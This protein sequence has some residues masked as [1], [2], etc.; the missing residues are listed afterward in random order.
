VRILE[1]NTP[2][3]REQI[4]VHYNAAD[5]R[6]VSY[7]LCRISKGD[8]ATDSVVYI[9]DDKAR[10]LKTLSYIHYFGGTYVTGENLYL[11]TVPDTTFLA[12]YTLFSYDQNGN[13]AQLDGYNINRYGN[14]VHCSTKGFSNY[15]QT[16]NPQYSEDEI[17]LMDNSFDGVIN[18]SKNNFI[19]TGIY[20]KK[21]EYRADGRPRTCL[22][23][24]NGSFA[25]TLTFVYK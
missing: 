9:H 10:L 19:N 21:Y 25:F 7:T 17:R 6:N 13:L 5:P 14:P 1:P 20:S 11:H 23:Y 2:T 3:N 4:E 16:I 15:S 24:Q 22:V 8:P 18:A 12:A